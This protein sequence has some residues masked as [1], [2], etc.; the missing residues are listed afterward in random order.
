MFLDNFYKTHNC[1]NVLNMVEKGAL[2]TV[3]TVNR[4]IE[5]TWIC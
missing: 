5:E 4:N 2:G 3:K 1:S